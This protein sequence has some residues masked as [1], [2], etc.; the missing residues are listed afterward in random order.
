M[1]SFG[2]M[3]AAATESALQIRAAQKE[4]MQLMAASFVTQ[5]NDPVRRRHAQQ[6]MQLQ[7]TT[8]TAAEPEDAG[9]GTAKYEW[10]QESLS[11]A[12]NETIQQGDADIL[13]GMGRRL[14]ATSAKAPKSRK[15]AELQAARSAASL[16]RDE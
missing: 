4:G 15:A 2:A 1:S 10:V 16:I 9:D 12:L 13:G 6:I 3:Q 5:I 7:T 11:A 14:I 8:P